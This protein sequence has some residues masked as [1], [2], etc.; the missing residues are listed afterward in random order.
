MRVAILVDG[1]FFLRRF[2][3][4]AGQ[5]TADEMAA[6]MRRY[7]IQHVNQEDG[8][9]LYRIFFYDCPPLEKKAHGPISGKAADFSKGETAQFRRA[10]HRALKEQPDVAL[11]LG[12]LDEA[13]ARWVFRDEKT[14]PRLLKGRIAL[15][16]L[17]DGDFRYHAP[18]KGVDARIGLDIAAMSHKR[19]AERIVLISGDSDF[20]PVAKTARREGIRVTLDPMWHSVKLDLREHVDV[21]RCNFPRPPERKA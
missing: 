5:R 9:R 14:L 6:E 16:D 8:E 12:H 18:Q 19:Q 1:D 17:T 13:N 2:T 7:C 3:V 21:V 10:L 15:S 4:L 11:R 20:I